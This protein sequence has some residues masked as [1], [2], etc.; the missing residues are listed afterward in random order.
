[1]CSDCY[2][3]WEQA[4]AAKGSCG[5]CGG[6]LGAEK[7]EAFRNNPGEVSNRLHDG[8]CLDYFSLVSAEAL[9]G[10]T[11]ITRQAARIEHQPVRSIEY[12]PQMRVPDFE[13][14]RQHRG[15]PVKV[16][17]LRATAKA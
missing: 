10:G 5:V 13:G 3:R 9:V 2:A 16:I 7:L 6:Y 15:K 8:K 12:V 11:G 1:M 4:V 14:M 17:P